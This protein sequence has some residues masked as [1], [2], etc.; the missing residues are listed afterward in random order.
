MGGTMNVDAPEGTK[1]FVWNG[2]PG[3]REAVKA[4]FEALMSTGGYP[5]YV[6]APGK[7]TAIRDFD[8]APEASEIRLTPRLMGG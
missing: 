2:V 1:T 3:E 7:P 6:E 4:E 8:E 5:A